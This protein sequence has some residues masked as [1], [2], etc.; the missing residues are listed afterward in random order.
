[1]NVRNDKARDRIEWAIAVI[2]LAGWVAF[3][4]WGP[5]P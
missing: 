2:G 1:M 4:I 5:L 3:V